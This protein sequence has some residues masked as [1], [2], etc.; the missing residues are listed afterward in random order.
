MLSFAVVL[1]LLIVC[2]VL[3]FFGYF[4]WEVGVVVFYFGVVVCVLVC[5]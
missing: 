4:L 2:F 1:F 5:L 3:L